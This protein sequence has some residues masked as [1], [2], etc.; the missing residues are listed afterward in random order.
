MLFV[1]IQDLTLFMRN[2]RNLLVHRLSPLEIL[3]STAR[4]S[5]F[6]KHLGSSSKKLPLKRE[7]FVHSIDFI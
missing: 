2:Y 6:K 7:P 5:Y 1:K 3:F 4:S